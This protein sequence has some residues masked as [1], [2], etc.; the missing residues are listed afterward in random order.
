M[1]QSLI[2]VL[3]LCIDTFVTS[4]VYSS[5]KI[6]IPVVS[7]LIIDTICSLFLAISLFFGYLIKDFIP[8]NIASTIS[9]LL[10]LILGVYRLFEAFFKNLIKRYYDKGSPLTFK[11]FEF[12]FILQIYADEIKADLDESKILSPKEAFF[13][14]VALSLDS[15]TVG[16]GCSLGTVNYLATVLLSFLVGALL[17]VL[18]GY[19]GKKIS[20]NY[21]L[22]LSCLSGVLLIILAFIR[23]I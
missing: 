7:G 21:N 20:K 17:L 13:L 23:I 4:I 3:S 9:F 1:V 12:K 5:N 11:I 10:L 2:L 8:I 14:A 19:V 6:K 18:G 15:L 22:N 16:F